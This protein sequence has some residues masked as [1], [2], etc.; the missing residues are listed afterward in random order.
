MTRLSRGFVALSAAALL[1]V[2][3]TTPTAV[4]STSPRPAAAQTERQLVDVPAQAA[5]RDAVDPSP[6]GT[7]LLDQYLD[8]VFASLTDEQFSFLVDHQDTLLNVPTYDALFFGTVGDPDFA[9]DAHAAQLQHTF[10]DVKGFW[11]DVK[12]DD[13]QLIAMHGESLLS[14]SR[15]TRT[16]TAMQAAGVIAPTSPAA[17]QAEAE[18]V[19]GFMATQGDFVDNPLWTFNAFAF[20]GAGDPDP[21]VAALP[22]KL[23]F[24]DGILDAYDAIGLGDVGPRVIMAH[25]F[26]HHVQF[27]IG[28]FGSGPADPAEATRRTEL[29]ADAYASYYGVHKLGLALNKKRVVD[30]LLSFYTVGDCQF[31]SPGHHGTPLQRQRAAQWGAD[32]AA[33]AKPQSYVLPARTFQDRF[34]AALAGIVAG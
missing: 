4:A 7:T 24:G 16:L 31:A 21:V 26:G 22:D 9:L 8:G 30:A 20:S 29:M 25:E 19:A 32:Q 3:L 23:V 1:S 28:T 27:E 15:I 33:A 17:I 13:I 12:S 18:T 6:C 2:G 14:V 11:S 34:D 5:L 10:R